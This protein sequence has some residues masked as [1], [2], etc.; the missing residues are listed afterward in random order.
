MT[1]I[2]KEFNICLRYIFK[3]VNNSTYQLVLKCLNNITCVDNSVT[4]I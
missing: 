4:T 3:A 2:Y 1:F